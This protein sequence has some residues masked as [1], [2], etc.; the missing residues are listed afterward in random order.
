MVD[1]QKRK[2]KAIPSWQ[3]ERMQGIIADRWNEVWETVKT[4]ELERKN[5]NRFINRSRDKYN[6]SRFDR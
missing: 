6:S 4:R 3:I 5:S 1:K 2:E